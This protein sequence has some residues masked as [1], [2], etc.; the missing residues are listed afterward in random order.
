MVEEVKEAFS[1]APIQEFTSCKE[2]AIAIKI[3]EKAIKKSK[4][5]FNQTILLKDCYILAEQFTYNPERT[6]EPLFIMVMS[7][8]PFQVIKVDL[9]VKKIENIKPLYKT[10][11]Y[12]ISGTNST[13][14]L[15]AKPVKVNLT[16][17]LT[18]FFNEETGKVVTNLVLD[19][20]DEKAELETAKATKEEV[21]KIIKDF[22]FLIGFVGIK[23]MIIPILFDDDAVFQEIKG[24]DYSTFTGK[25]FSQFLTRVE[26]YGESSRQEIKVP[27]F[28]TKPKIYVNMSNLDKEA[29]TL[30]R[31][32]NYQVDNYTF[33]NNTTFIPILFGDISKTISDLENS[34]QISEL[35]MAT[36]VNSIIVKEY[37][38]QIE[39][40]IK[41]N[42]LSIEDIKEIS[43][44]TDEI[45]VF[46]QIASMLIKDK[47][48][49]KK[50]DLQIMKA[51][52]NTKTL[53]ADNKPFVSRDIETLLS[54]IAFYNVAKTKNPEYKESQS[55]SL[56]DTI[57]AI[58][59]RQYQI[60]FVDFKNMFIKDYGVSEKKFEEIVGNVIENEGFIEIRQQENKTGPE[61]ENIILTKSI[62]T[63]LGE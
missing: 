47:Y 22:P 38:E 4:Q 23:K 9:P 35:K 18:I 29:V 56:S 33:D 20:V 37:K 55:Q 36:Y 1:D 7:E 11:E 13:E 62:E 21:L 10:F 48:K 19:K 50:E 45:K 52:F 49:F 34:N 24:I 25:G 60:P 57:K 53:L 58:I 3:N 8:N 15:F 31:A 28:I 14:L 44:T 6:E 51:I 40:L 2:L 63:F 41:N 12:S 5:D 32:M 61:S 42:P 54:V 59:D 39:K 17:Q 30:M 43:M 46:T 27:V 26:I 16:L